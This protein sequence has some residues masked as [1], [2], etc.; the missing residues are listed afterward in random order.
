MRA[1]PIES[2]LAL[3]EAEM[4]ARNPTRQQTNFC[5]AVAPILHRVERAAYNVLRAAGLLVLACLLAALV[6]GG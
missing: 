2:F 4:T 5:S 3:E 6:T 1:R